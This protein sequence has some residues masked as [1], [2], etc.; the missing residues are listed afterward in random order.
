MHRKV[1]LYIQ[2]DAFASGVLVLCRATLSITFTFTTFKR[3]RVTT[4]EQALQ[5]FQELAQHV[6]VFVW[7]AV[8]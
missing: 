3:F 6:P 4:A 8:G 2:G 5:Y 7:E 1:I